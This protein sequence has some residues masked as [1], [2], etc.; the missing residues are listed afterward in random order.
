MKKIFFVLC[1]LS[2]LCC[3]SQKKYQTSH[4]VLDIIQNENFSDLNTDVIYEIKIYIIDTYHSKMELVKD[5]NHLY[6]INYVR[7]HYSMYVHVIERN[8]IEYLFDSIFRSGD[9][10]IKLDLEK[11]EQFRPM[12]M[13]PKIVIDFIMT[14][15]YRPRFRLNE[16]DLLTIGI[17]SFGYICIGKEENLYYPNVRLLNFIEEYFHRIVRFYSL[18]KSRRN[19]QSNDE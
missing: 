4:E 7:S 16:Q 11:K 10:L 15:G 19:G 13:E 9:T 12:F 6:D 2:T 18:E 8:T 14:P 5:I 1:I 3:M 17:D